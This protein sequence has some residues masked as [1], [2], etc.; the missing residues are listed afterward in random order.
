MWRL[1]WG[2]WLAYLGKCV[3]MCVELVANVWTVSDVVFLTTEHF[4]GI[5]FKVFKTTT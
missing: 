4:I 5:R 2:L 3:V 1:C